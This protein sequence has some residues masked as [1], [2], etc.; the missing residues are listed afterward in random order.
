MKYKLT[1]L[2]SQRSNQTYLP[3]KQRFGKGPKRA[4][5]LQDS[6]FKL[7]K[8]QRAKEDLT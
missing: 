8:P 2:P 6:P 5:Q 1:E 4:T 7:A 3:A